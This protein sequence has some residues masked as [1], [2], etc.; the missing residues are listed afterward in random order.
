MRSTIQLGRRL[1]SEGLLGISR[2]TVTKRATRL[3]P[4][5]FCLRIP[6]SA[7]LGRAFSVM[8]GGPGETCQDRHDDYRSNDGPFALAA[9]SRTLNDL[10]P[11]KYPYRADGTEHDPD[12][13][14]HPHRW[15]HSRHQD[16]I[17]HGVTPTDGRSP[18]GQ[19]NHLCHTVGRAMQIA[20]GQGIRRFLGH[21]VGQPFSGST[22]LSAVLPIWGEG[23][24]A[25]L[26]ARFALG[27]GSRLSHP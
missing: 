3:W 11:L 19:P 4:W 5:A 1:R 2:A 21:D 12:C 17:D 16:R 7:R 15:L 23:R 13:R 10:G 26:A 25:S 24:T 9:H 27:P 14:S 20:D 8:S 6:G 18:E 22:C